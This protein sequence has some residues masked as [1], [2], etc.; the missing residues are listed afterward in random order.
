MDEQQIKTVGRQIFQGLF[1][2]GNNVVAVSD[3]MAEYIF[4]PGGRGDTTLRYDLHPLTQVRRQF[5]RFAKRGLTLITAV[6]IRMV[7]GRDAQIKMLFNKADQL[8]RRHIPVHQ[9]P[10][11]HHEA[12]KFRALRG[13]SD[14][15]N[16]NR[17]LIY[18][19]LASI[20]NYGFKRV[21][22]VEVLPAGSVCLRV[23]CA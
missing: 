12:R 17:F 9:T 20:R 11:T 23:I 10:V 8:T 13:N 15:L 3:V 22:V 5:Q 2:A 4:S 7:N 16:H 1:S 18:R 6:D 21:R 19:C 14:T